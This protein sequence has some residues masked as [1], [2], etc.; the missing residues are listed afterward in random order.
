MN[1]MV[2]NVLLTLKALH[3]GSDWRNFTFDKYCTAHVDQ[4]NCHAALA[5]YD[6]AP[7][8]ESMTVHYFEDGSLNRP[9]PWLRPQSWLTAQ[10]SKILTP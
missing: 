7:L 8:E 6:V 2:A 4:H 10:D 3:Y 9:L 5:E 1:T